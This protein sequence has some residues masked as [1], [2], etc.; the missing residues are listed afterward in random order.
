MLL[1]N[2]EEFKRVARNWAIKYAEAAPKPG[3]S[4]STN[5]SAHVKVDL[6]KERSEG[7]K[8]R[9]RAQY[10]AFHDGR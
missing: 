8:R 6:E 1:T 4:S 5:H 3:E 10:V 7:E 9:K 2:P